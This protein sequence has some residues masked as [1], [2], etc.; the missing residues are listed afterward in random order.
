M[1]AVPG[2]PLVWRRRK[3]EYRHRP[4]GRLLFVASLP[5]GT[6]IEIRCP[7]CGQ[8]HIIDV[9]VPVPPADSSPEPLTAD[10]KSVKL[11]LTE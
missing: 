3:R 10:N 2:A 8:M 11:G 6:R 4:C 7:A 5:P 9:P 1:T